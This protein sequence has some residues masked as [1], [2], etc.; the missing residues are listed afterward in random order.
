MAVKTTPA[1]RKGKAKAKAKARA[2]SW[3]V[4]VL[5]SLSRGYLYTG[6]ARDV[7]RRVAE[8]NAG[9]GAK[10]ARAHRPWAIVWTE[11]GHTHSTALRREHAIKKM[12]RAAKLCLVAS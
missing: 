10:Y 7:T 12:T 6:I 9:K 8:H 11:Q 4:Y 2:K 5:R 1:A 3:T